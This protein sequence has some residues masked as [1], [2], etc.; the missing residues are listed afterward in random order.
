MWTDRRT[1][2]QTDMTKPID[3]FRNSAN[4]L[5]FL[6]GTLCILRKA[7]QDTMDPTLTVQLISVLSSRGLHVVGPN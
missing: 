2:G 7:S 1:D 3:P 5:F 4:R 6:A